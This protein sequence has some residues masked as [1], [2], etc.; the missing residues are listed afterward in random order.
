MSCRYVL[1]F[2]FAPQRLAYRMLRS[3]ACTGPDRLESGARGRRLERVWPSGRARLGRMQTNARPRRRSDEPRLRGLPADRVRWNSG[4][5]NVYFRGALILVVIRAFSWDR[6]RG[7]RLCFTA[8][9]GGSDRH[10]A[11]S[12]EAYRVGVIASDPTLRL[13][14]VRLL[15]DSL[16]SGCPKIVNPRACEVVSRAAGFG[17]AWCRSDLA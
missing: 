9:E 17:A 1:F 15:L 13:I 5:C 4:A 12:G 7:A 16:T 14:A 10:P 6:S 11:Y 8:S 2:S 3:A